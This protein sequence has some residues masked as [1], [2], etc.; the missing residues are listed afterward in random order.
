MKNQALFSLRDKSE[1]LNCRLLQFWFV[2]VK[3]H[4]MEYVRFVPFH[5][6]LYKTLTKFHGICEFDE[7]LCEICQTYV[8]LPKTITSELSKM[9]SNLLFCVLLKNTPD[10][11]QTVNF[12]IK[13]MSNK[14]YHQGKLTEVCKVLCESASKREKLTL[15]HS[16]RPKLYTILAF[17]S[18]IGFRMILSHFW[19]MGTLSGETTPSF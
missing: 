6:L 2:R 17:L 18:A 5:I 16:E 15:L 7:V 11:M 19:I 13:C 1:K 9:V 14:K 12:F 8:T 3:T 10:F 4:S